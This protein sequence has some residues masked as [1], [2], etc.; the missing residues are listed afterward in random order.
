MRR[1]ILSLILIFVFC[2]I[3]KPAWAQTAWNLVPDGSGDA[4]H[5]LS[6]DGKRVAYHNISGAVDAADDSTFV[7]VEK[8]GSVS[9]RINSDLAATTVGAEGFMRSCVGTTASANECDPVYNDAG[10]VTMNGDPA[11]GRAATYGEKAVNL[12]WDTTI[13]DSSK[14]ARVWVA[15]DP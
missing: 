6:P 4:V 1:I 13:N 8:C 7:N 5:Q 15:C 11:A 3:A 10:A 9:W 14:T 12:Y 2:V